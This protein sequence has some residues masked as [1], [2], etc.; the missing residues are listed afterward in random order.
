MVLARAKGDVAKTRV[1]VARQMLAE[2]SLRT[3][4][5]RASAIV[6]SK[7]RQI[8]TTGPGG[9]EIPSPGARG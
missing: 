7:K 2:E 3:L 9:F 6:P 1:A 5:R 8:A 4:R